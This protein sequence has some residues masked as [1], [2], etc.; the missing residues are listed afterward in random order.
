MT[1]GFEFVGD[2]DCHAIL[3][4]GAVW[5]DQSAE[6]LWTDIDGLA[7]HRWSWATRKSTRLTLR[8]RL[9]SFAL[10]D[11]EKDTL[12]AASEKTFHLLSRET[13]ATRELARVDDG[14]AHTRLNDGRC[15]R[16]GRFWAGTMAEQRPAP[17]GSFGSLY[18]LQPGCAPR[19][20]LS[21]VMISNSL[22]WSPDGRRMY[23]ADSPTNLIRSFAFDPA[24]GAIGEGRDFAHTATG[25]HPDGSCVDAEGYVWNAQWGAS[26]VVRY[27]PAG[28][29]DLVL[30][31]PCSQPS[32]TAFGGPDLD[33]LFITTASVGL[34]EVELASEPMAGNILIYRTPFRGLKESRASRAFLAS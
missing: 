1:A 20:T 31:L 6:F 30:H 10:I 15:D 8:E 19:G 4:E 7:L 34:S 11:G 32:C 24:T 18:C 23:F 12:I 16:H 17:D 27:S 25:V 2:I 9:G 5:D 29:I 26:C 33:H 28:E 22:C 3:G 21:R 14:F 13:G